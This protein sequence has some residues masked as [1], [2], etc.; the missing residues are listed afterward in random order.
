M[1]GIIIASLSCAVLIFGYI[2]LFRWNIVPVS[3]DVAQI[4]EVS[5]LD[6]GMIVF[7]L[8]LTDGYEVNYA[9]Y[10]KDANGDFY[11]TPYRPIIKRKPIVDAGGLHNTFYVITQSNS[12][13]AEWADKY[14]VEL[15]EVNALYYGTEKD[16]VL[17]WDNDMDLPPA[18]D[19]VEDEF[20]WN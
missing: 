17:I 4:S 18:S 7:H 14:G 19:K 15:D 12:W 10:K 6:N 2:G 13:T 16:R 1:K 11:V 9:K 3:S 8:K 5:Q 20:N